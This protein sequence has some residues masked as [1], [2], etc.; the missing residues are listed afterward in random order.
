MRYASVLEAELG[1]E[2]L[3]VFDGGRYSK[4][5]I[6]SWGVLLGD[7]VH[8]ANGSMHMVPLDE[9]G[10]DL[11]L[12]EGFARVIDPN[13]PLDEVN[14]HYIVKTHRYGTNRPI[15]PRINR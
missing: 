8:P 3:L 2:A 12:H 14:I 11:S 5:E 1:W 15:A 6:K 13:S 7:L 4:V 9:L 10:N